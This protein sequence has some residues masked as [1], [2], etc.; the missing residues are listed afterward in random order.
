MT[1]CCIINALFTNSELIKKYEKAGYKI[2]VS[3]KLTAVDLEYHNIFLL[4]Y[5]IKW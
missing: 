2:R 4:G 3:Q 5:Y 1:N